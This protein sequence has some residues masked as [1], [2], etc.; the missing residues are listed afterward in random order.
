MEANSSHTACPS[1]CIFEGLHCGRGDA[2]VSKGRQGLRLLRKGRP[3]GFGFLEIVFYYFFVGKIWFGLLNN[4]LIIMS[5]EPR[6]VPSSR[7]SK[8]SMNSMD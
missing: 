1:V 5:F 6:D 4:G 8:W 7:A 2:V 3:W